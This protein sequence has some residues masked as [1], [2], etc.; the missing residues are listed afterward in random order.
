MT[1][2]LSEKTIFGE[3]RLPGRVLW[4]SQRQSGGDLRRCGYDCE[5]FSGWGARENGFDPH[6]QMGQLNVYQTEG[7]LEKYHIPGFQAA[8]DCCVSSIMPTMP[9]RPPPHIGRQPYIM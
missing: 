3:Q 6:Y 1:Q 5:A 7:S 8:V 2:N 4:E 9:S